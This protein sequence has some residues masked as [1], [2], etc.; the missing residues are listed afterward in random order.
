MKALEKYSKSD[1]TISEIVQQVKGSKPTRASEERIQRQKENIRIQKA[2]NKKS[3]DK[4]KA[5]E[6]KMK[7]KTKYS[8][9][10]KL[11]FANDIE[12][13]KENIRPVSHMEERLKQLEGKDFSFYVND[14]FNRPYKVKRSQ[15]LKMKNNSLFIN[16]L[17]SGIKSTIAKLEKSSDVK[18][19]E[20]IAILK[21]RLLKV[22]NFNREVDSIGNKDVIKLT[23]KEKQ[24]LKNSYSTGIAREEKGNKYPLNVI[25]TGEV[26]SII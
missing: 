19:E 11:G 8:L 20:K 17:E 5:L 4:I 26:I 21:D 18:K 12:I 3:K 14:G 23:R 22:V 25:I 13:E 24:L 1:L 2:K 15:I 16:K 9:F 10:D 6:S 7:S